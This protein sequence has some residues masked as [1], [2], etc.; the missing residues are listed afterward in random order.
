[1]QQARLQGCGREDLEVVAADLGIGIFAGDDLALL[2]DADL[3]VTAPPGW[4]MIAS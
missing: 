4:A 3:A 2:G 1:M